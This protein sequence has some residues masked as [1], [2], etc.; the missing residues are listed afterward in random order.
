MTPPL[1]V[2]IV[3]YLNSRPL[4][5]SFLRGTAG[6]GIEAVFLPP[7]GV[8]DSLASGQ[9][10]VG[11]IPSIEVKRI[12]GL[13]ILPGPCVAATREVRSVLL[14]SSCPASEIR[15]LALDENSRTSAALVQILLREH[16]GLEPDIVPA[17]PDLQTMMA[18][19]DAALIIGD[20]ALQVD[21]SGFIVHDLAAEW[22]RLTGRPFVFAVWAKRRE[23]DL[24]RH[25]QVFQKSLEHGL[26]EMEVLIAEAAS[27]LSLESAAVR[28]Y[29]T[30]CL[31]F[32]L[33]ASE[34]AGLEEFYYRASQAGLIDASS[35]SVEGETIE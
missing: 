24:G 11:L 16:H 25:S 31:T 35:C 10:D 30:E 21:R 32:D 34:R 2:G 13:E 17:A 12:P 14:L 27:E 7:A 1:R 8:A 22:R 29:L 23:V 9:L 28:E 3:N 15:R 18:E 33:G 26:T 4:A 20:P 19:A 5:W 6:E